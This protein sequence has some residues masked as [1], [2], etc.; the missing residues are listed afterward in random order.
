MPT[1]RSTFEV[2]ALS[3]AVPSSPFALSV[4]AKRIALPVA[5]WERIEQRQVV[6]QRVV[7]ESESVA[8]SVAEWIREKVK[9]RQTVSASYR[10]QEFARSP[11]LP[12]VLWEL[13]SARLRAEPHNSARE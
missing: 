13:A 4:A 12:G 8:T 1:R 5:M 9:E 7:F 2:A 10:R 6:R 3:R 11:Q